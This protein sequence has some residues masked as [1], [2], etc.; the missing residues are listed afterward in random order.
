M[1][2]PIT[3]DWAFIPVNAWI[4]D[5]NG[6]PWRVVER[7]TNLPAIALGLDD[8]TGKG[9]WVTRNAGEEVVMLDMSMD[10]ATALIASVLGG[11][12]EM[13]VLPQKDSKNTRAMW[14]AH[15]LH[16][17]HEYMVGEQDT[18][19]SLKEIH[20]LLH[21]KPYPSA[22]SHVHIP[23]HQMKAYGGSQ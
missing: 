17:H 6:K 12:V 3:T 2:D 10:R 18:L 19:D 22:L 4:S 11:V 13:D 7:R 15:L 20:A 21:A 14:K 8:G 1:P 16:H 5:A 9:V 23:V